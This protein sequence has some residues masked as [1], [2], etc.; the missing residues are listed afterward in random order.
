MG[1]QASIERDLRIIGSLLIIISFGITI[2]LDFSIL[3]NIITF[4]FDILTIMIWFFIVIS[5]KL[6]VEVIVEKVEKIIMPV[7]VYTIAMVTAG[8]ASTTN[9]LF[10]V[11]FIFITISNIFCL[12]CWHFSLSI[13]KKE[14]IAFFVTGILYILITLILRLLLI[15]SPIPLTIFIVSLLSFSIG[16]LLIIYAEYNM[17]KKGLLN[18]I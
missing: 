5:F 8:A 7:L 2:I 14:K 11:A 6:E 17:K 13:Y 9:S 16:F 18:Y 3:N 10:S 15:V 1:L 12:L 4:I